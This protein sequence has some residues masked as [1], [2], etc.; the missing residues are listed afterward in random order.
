MD[1]LLDC[2]VDD[3]VDDL[4]LRE[5][6]EDQ[7]R[8]E[9][10]QVRCKCEVIVGTE[11]R[12]E[13]QLRERQGVHSAAGHDDQGR[14]DVVPGAEGGQDRDGGVHRFHER[15]NDFPVRRPGGG[16][17]DMSGFFER[18]RDVLEVAGVQEHVHR[19][20]EDRVAQDDTDH[21]GDVQFCRLFDERHHQDRERDEHTA[22]DVVVRRTVE[23]AVLHVARNSIPHQGVDDKCQSHRDAGD[24]DTVEERTPEVGDFHRL[25]EIAEAPVLRQRQDAGDAVRHLARLFEG[26]DDGHIEREQHRDEA[27][28]QKDG[29][30][31]V[32]FFFD[33][34]SRKIVVGFHYSCSSLLFRNLI[35]KTEMVTMTMKKM[36]ALALWKPNWPPDIPLL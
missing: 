5:Q 34:Q 12:L 13:G 10:E 6:I 7:H 24:E 14:H 3:T 11:L 31:P 29:Q 4:F 23:F 9:G 19:H 18:H 20:V 28:D 25:T 17:V 8:Q 27:E 32:E 30:R 22:D 35:W 21:V 36:T 2:A 33:F 15:E 1:G 16:A 26:D